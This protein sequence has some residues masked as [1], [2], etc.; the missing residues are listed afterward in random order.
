MS[1]SEHITMATSLS[2]TRLLIRERC[3]V[4]PAEGGEEMGEMGVGGVAGCIL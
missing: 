1:T 3:V 4:W 2:E